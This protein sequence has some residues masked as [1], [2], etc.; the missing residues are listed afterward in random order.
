TATRQ[1]PELRLHLIMVDYE[2]LRSSLDDIKQLL[3]TISARNMKLI[4]ASRHEGTDG[5]LKRLRL[6]TKA[7]QSG[8]MQQ[9]SIVKTGYFWAT[10]SMQFIPQ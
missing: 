3:R 9:D 2:A 4:T 6:R 5:Y 10:L 1:G 8:S 7:T